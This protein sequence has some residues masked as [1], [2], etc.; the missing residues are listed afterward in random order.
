MKRL[1]F[2]ALTATG[3]THHSLAEP[4][5]SPA[6]GA[7][8]QE[9]NN[10]RDC[11]NGELEVQDKRLN[12]AYKA[13]MTVLPAPRKETLKKAQRLWIPFRDAHCDSWVDLSPTAGTMQQEFHA[14]C[15]LETTYERADKLE[16]LLNIVKEGN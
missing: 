15:H 10:P 16:K 14:Y 8:I 11:N 7:C 13:L 4:A 9:G 3:F 2:L 12:A 6:Y 5:F 1:V